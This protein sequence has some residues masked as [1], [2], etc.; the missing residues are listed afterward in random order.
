MQEVSYTA[1]HLRQARKNLPLHALLKSCQFPVGYVYNSLQGGQSP[2]SS[3]YLVVSL[4]KQTNNSNY[5]H[6]RTVLYQLPEEWRDI[7]WLQDLLRLRTRWGLEGVH[8]FLLKVCRE[9]CCRRLDRFRTIIFWHLDHVR[10]QVPLP[11]LLGLHA[12][13]MDIELKF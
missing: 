2:F 4:Q 8:R 3:I 7:Q 5:T 6:M 13:G 9:W 1:I 10:C 12:H 11:G